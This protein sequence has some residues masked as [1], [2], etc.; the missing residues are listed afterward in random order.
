[1]PS[2]VWGVE[3]EMERSSSWVREGGGTVRR[4]IAIV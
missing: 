1:M 2:K 3:E 4:V